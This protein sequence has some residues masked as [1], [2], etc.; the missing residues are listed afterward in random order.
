MSAKIVA[1]IRAVLGSTAAIDDATHAI[2]D[3]QIIAAID[4]WTL[5]CAV[6]AEN[7]T[8]GM[9]ISFDDWFRRS[10]QNWVHEVVET[11]GADQRMIRAAI[12]KFARA[13]AHLDGETVIREVEK[14]RGLG[15][16]DTDLR[17]ESKPPR[18]LKVWFPTSARQGIRS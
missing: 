17:A 13:N 8:N 1:F 4:A 15:A 10:A 2:G 9:A 11:T 16:E 12:H 5:R 18:G 6:T 7:G 3:E 14:V